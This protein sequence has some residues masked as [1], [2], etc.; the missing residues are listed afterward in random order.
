MPE[1]AGRKS[2]CW[3]CEKEFLLTPVNMKN[4]KPLCDNCEESVDI[5]DKYLQERLH[6]AKPTQQD[7]RTP[8]QEDEVEVYDPDNE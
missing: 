2:I 5:L 3:Q 1:P 7:T 4:D 6:K 8:V